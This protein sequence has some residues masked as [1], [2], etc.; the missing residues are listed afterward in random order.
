VCP[1]SPPQREYKLKHL[2]RE[3]FQQSATEVLLALKQLGAEACGALFT[4]HPP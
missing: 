1:S 4:D 3:E 2:S